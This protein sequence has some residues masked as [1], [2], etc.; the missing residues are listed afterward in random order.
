MFAPAGVLLAHLFVTFPYMLGAVKPLLDELETTY[1]EAAY[2]IG[3]SR[4]QTF[5]LVILPALRGGLFTGA[6]LTF[7]HSLGEFGAT[8][9][10]VRQPAAADPDRAALH[11]RPVRGR[12]HRAR[13][14]GRRGAGAALV[15]R[16]SSSCSASR[17]GPREGER[18]AADV[19]HPRDGS[20]SA[21][22]AD[23]VVEAS[24]SRS[25]TGE[26]FV[27]LGASGSGK[28][29]IL[30]MIAG[31]A[32]PD[33]GRILLAG[34]RCH[35]PPAAAARHRIRLPE[36]LDLPAHDRGEEHR[37]RPEDPRG[38]ARPSGAAGA[39]S[40]STSS[41]SAG[42][43][44]RYANQLSGGQ[45]QRVA[46]ARALAYEPEVLLLDEPFGAL[47]VKIRAQLRRSLNEIQR[48]RS[49]VTTILVTHDQEEA[50]ELGRSHRR[51]GSRAAWSRSGARGLYR[52]RA[53]SSPRPSSA[54]ARC[55]SDAA[56]RTRRSSARSLCPCP[57][58]VHHVGRSAGASS[59]PA[60]TGDPFG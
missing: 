40:C 8:V 14:R 2:T 43:G 17:R 21:T 24:T 35:A 38:A 22:P 45:Q 59:D 1:E 48:Q 9:H 39:R 37:V 42:L 57:K 13:E 7:A 4:W 3:A 58:D 5:R 27:L 15:R 53:R 55:S 49:R 60:G 11:L 25:P 18:G 46:L 50:F 47:D 54:R 6:L 51:H 56:G 26:L 16:S 41:A 44:D 52:G 19:D 30:R 33:E 31:L 20:P 10:G 28:S 32:S 36:L 23:A 34:T 29:T 12:Q